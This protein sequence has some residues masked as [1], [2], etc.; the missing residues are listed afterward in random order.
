MFNLL[1]WLQH[2][3][4]LNR[5]GRSLDEMIEKLAAEA[6]ARGSSEDEVIR[7]IRRGLEESGVVVAEELRRIMPRMIREHTRFRRR[8]ERNLRKRW[9]NALDLYYAVYVACQEVGEDYADR[10]RATAMSENDF[11]FEALVRLHAR[12]C[13]VA[14]EIFALLRTGHALGASARARTLHEIAA[15]GF[16]LAAGTVA[17]AERYLLHE[18]VD[19]WKRA[20]QYQSVATRLG[21]EPLSDEEMGVIQ[22]DLNAL[23][24]RF[25]SEFARPYGWAA[26][27]V[28]KP[29]PTFRDLE[30]HV[31]LDH[32]R[33]YYHWFSDSI[34]AGARAAHEIVQHRG[35]HAVLLAGASNAGL[36][37]PAQVA[38]LSLSQMTST[39]VLSGIQ[40]TADDLVA[41]T[42]ISE[43]RD[44]AVEAFGEA[45][46]EL[47]RDEAAIQWEV[48]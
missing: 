32:L 39:L 9:G 22:D 33:P 34:H 44:A 25:G 1:G 5:G 24:D 6:I 42:A 19:R 37:D 13:T 7:G 27:I 2:L 29:R 48:N 23:V 21:E 16:V 36:W 11:R 14:S 18:V 3:R 41:V 15:T 47:E 31:K 35:P 43:L 26:P 40:P 20:C 12:A 28:G 17:D 46:R 10:N 4:I 8:F 38:M 30:N 45:D